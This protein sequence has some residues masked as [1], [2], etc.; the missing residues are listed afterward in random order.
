M[1]SESL[2]IRQNMIKTPGAIKI[3]PNELSQP[4]ETPQRNLFDSIE[5]N[6]VESTNSPDSNAI[7][8]GE[9]KN[10]EEM[11]EEKKRLRNCPLD[12]CISNNDVAE[13]KPEGRVLV[14]YTGGT[15]GMVRNERGGK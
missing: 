1:P 9:N 14:L 11:E 6:I 2:A 12:N 10:E 7:E 8:T 4:E 15:I 13:I 5:E 3:E